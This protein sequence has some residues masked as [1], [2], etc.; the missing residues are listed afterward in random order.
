MSDSQEYHTPENWDYITLEGL[1]LLPAMNV[2]DNQGIR[3]GLVSGLSRSDA[4]D[5]IATQAGLEKAICVEE[6]AAVTIE[7]K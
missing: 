6:F 5:Q 1:G 4:F 3:T 7:M 2:H